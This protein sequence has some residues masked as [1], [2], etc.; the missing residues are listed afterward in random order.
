MAAAYLFDLVSNH[1][2]IDG[3][4][5][6]GSLAAVVFLEMNGVDVNV[7]EEQFQELVLEVAAGQSGKEE[8]TEFFR[9]HLPPLPS[10]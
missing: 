7:P 3:N 8:V 5:R 1:P 2:F 10:V 6:T 9:Q 4:K